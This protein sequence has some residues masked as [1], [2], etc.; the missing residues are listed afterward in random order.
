MRTGRVYTETTIYAAPRE[1][2]A[3]AP[4]QLVIVTFDDDGSRMT[5]RVTGEAVAIDD[6][7][8]LAEER[9]GVPVFRRTMVS[10]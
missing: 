5:G 3:E 1:F 9:A 7:V 2:L 6:A 4:Y 8:E 10:I